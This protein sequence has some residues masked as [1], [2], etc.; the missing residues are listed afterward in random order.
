MP[1]VTRTVRCQVSGKDVPLDQALPA[2]LVRESLLPVL[3]ETCDPWDPNGYISLE[4]LNKA[5]LKHVEKFL[6]N[7]D[8]RLRQ[9]QQ[10]V[11]HSIQERQI[12][13]RDTTEDFDRQLSFGE[14]MADKIAE[15]GG[16]WTFIG[17]FGLVLVVWMGVNTVGIFKKP[18]DPYPFIFL[19]LVLSCVAAIQ[20]PVIM[21]SQNRQEERDRLHADNDY[22]VNLKAEL[23]IRHLNEKVDRLLNEQWKH[24][25]EIQQ[26]QMEMLE[27][28]QQRKPA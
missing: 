23:E 9:A 13:S 15:F 27:E 17:I 7:P 19:N 11:L 28:M 16:S 21:M 8:D 3:K 5:R 4:E 20:A 24:L 14:R 2:D 6:D 22:K 1:T 26:M 18:F 12:L 25:L 10:E